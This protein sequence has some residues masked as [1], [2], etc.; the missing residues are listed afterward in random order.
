[1]DF[2]PVNIHANPEGQARLK[3]HGLT[4]VPAVCV[5]DE[6]VSGV[7]LLAVATLVGIPYEERSMLPPDSL[8]RKFDLVLA[9]AC[10]Y[11]RQVPL[12]ALAYKSPDRDRSLRALGLHIFDL[13]LAFLQGYES[14]TLRLGG[15]PAPADAAAI[16]GA[17][18]AALGDEARAA[19]ARWWQETGRFD[20]L[21]RVIETYWGAHTLHEALERE[22]WHTA[23][24]TRQVMM[25]L[26]QLEVEPDGPL[27][28]AELEGLPLPES[29]W[30]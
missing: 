15:R 23:Q 26:S 17:E 13:P 5:G 16:S 21:D 19:L 22:T 2:E 12:Q 24:H 18:I 8:C 20:P 29:V 28:P 25:F 4:S 27:G 11:F 7:D 9:A 10:R 1:M 14:G 30:D 3:A 6:C